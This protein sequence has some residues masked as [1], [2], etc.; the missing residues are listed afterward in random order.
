MAKADKRVADQAPYPAA[1][2]NVRNSIQWLKDHAETYNIG[3]NRITLPDGS[4][5][6]HLIELFGY[7]ANTPT[8]LHP[9]GLGPKENQ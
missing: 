8:L 2:D 4:A 7:A 5:D 1:V 3:A 6:S 9:K